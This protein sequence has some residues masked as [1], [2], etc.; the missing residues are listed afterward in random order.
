MKRNPA[1]DGLRAVA[2]LMVMGDHA[3]LPHFAGGFI[4]VD[5]F[6]VLS[7][8]LISGIV[9]DEWLK[10]GG[11]R[12]RR[13]LYR[14]FL[15]LF[16]ALCLM[17]L[18]VLPVA[19]RLSGAWA[20]VTLD[21]GAALLY[22]TNL[23]R[24]HA[25][26]EPNLF[27]GHTWSL[28][29][30]QQFYL[31][32]PLGLV[33]CLRNGM[34]GRTL[35]RL[36]LLLL[37]G[38]LAWRLY[39]ALSQAPIPRLYNAPDTRL[40]GVLLGCLAGMALRLLD[41]SAIQQLSQLTARL[42]WPAVGLAVAVFLNLRIDGAYFA[43]GLPLTE[44]AACLLILDLHFR[45]ATRLARLLAWPL[46]SRLGLVSYGVYLW[47]YPVFR[48]L[49]ELACSKSLFIFGVGGA[50]SV[51]MAEL[52]FRFLETP[53]LNRQRMVSSVSAWARS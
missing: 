14:R 25:I 1:L 21:A 31:L 16:P 2:V 3:V 10:T 33:A 19:A 9:M 12:V 18:L 38:L 47:H 40:Q 43:W 36:S 29:V 49:N 35:L 50:L 5:I 45:P 53:I 24:M 27:Y 17:V 20:D 34:G 30:E 15:R 44:A 23:V 52:S 7:G 42:R 48:I 28:G 13:F 8:F 37:L 46:I 41:A 22:I 39:L 32:W 6:F 11:F 26:H 4:G 51:L